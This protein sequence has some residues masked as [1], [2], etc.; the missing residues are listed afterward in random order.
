MLI[1]RQMLRYNI[2][3]GTGQMARFSLRFTDKCVEVRP[4][5]SGGVG[6][7]TYFPTLSSTSIYLI[8]DGPRGGGGGGGGEGD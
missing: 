8:D 3:F 7:K 5:L 6:E 2:Q 4:V 1:K